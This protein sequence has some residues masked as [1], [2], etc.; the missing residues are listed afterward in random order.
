MVDEQP[1]DDE[2]LRLREKKL[3]EMERELA[4]RAGGA[5]REVTDATFQGFIQGNPRVLIDFWAEWCGPCRTLA[6]IVED[7]AAEFAGRVA[8]G[9]C[10]TDG[11]P[12]IARSY[13]ISAIPTLLLF[14]RGQLVDRI[15]GAYPAES[16]RA[17]IL[18]AFF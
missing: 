14:S 3:R 16:I 5:V 7:L 9:K 2:L 11:N 17:R 6:P 15:I 10:D 18:R 13:Q 8:V 1:Y 4:V 12:L